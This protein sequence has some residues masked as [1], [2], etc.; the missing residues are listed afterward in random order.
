M[1][2]L[3]ISIIILNYNGWQDTID[4]L[5][6]VYQTDYSNYDM[7]L[8]DNGSNDDSIEKIKKYCCGEIEVKSKFFEYNPNNKPIR[9]F[10]YE[11]GMENYDIKEYKSLDSDRK[12]ILIRNKKN[13]GFTEGNNIG[14]RFALKNLNPDY[15]LLLNNDTVIEKDLLKELV[16]TILENCRIALVQP[17]IISYQDLSIDNLGFSC[18]FLG[19][20]RPK[21]VLNNKN[22]FYLSGA[23][24]LINTDF[25]S[26]IT[27]NGEIFDKELFAYFED[28]DLSWRAR[29]LRYELKVNINTICYHKGSKTVKKINL[30]TYY[31]DYRNKLRVFIKNLSLPY[32]FIY[33]FLSLPIKFL[34]AVIKSV[35]SIIWNIKNLGN[36]LKYRVAVQKTRKISDKEILKRMILIFNFNKDRI[37]L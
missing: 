4:C 9:V 13:Y 32:L 11:E 29:L 19:N 36:T 27:K 14:I 2:V 6:S 16:K 31:L 21:K 17:K 34:L 35:K 26:E 10:E 28:V 33:L 37:I 23:C 20:T 7:V 24:L 25:I 22:L 18:D 8:I 3:R 1:R 15:I 5:E 30:N 12:L